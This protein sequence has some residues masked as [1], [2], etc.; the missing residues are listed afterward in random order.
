M[1]RAYLTL[2]LALIAPAIG[3]ILGL[4]LWLE[5]LAG[6]L[7]RLGGYS[8][9]AF[10]WRGRQQVFVPS[11]AQ[12]ANPNGRYDIIVIGDS[13][14]W[15][16]SADQQTRVGAFWTDFLAASTGASVGVFD[17]LALGI[18]GIFKTPAY[19]EHPPGLIILELVER[20]LQNALAAAGS[21]GGAVPEIPLATPSDPRT[22]PTQTYE[23]ARSGGSPRRGVG[24][25]VNYLRKNLPRWIAGEDL[26]P[27]VALTL[28]RSD[29]FS[30]QEPKTLLTYEDDFKKS[31]WTAADIE[32]I[33]CHLLRLQSRIESNGRTGFLFLMAP[34]KSSAYSPYLHKRPDWKE[35]LPMLIAGSALHAPRADLALRSAIADLVRDVYL[36]NDTHWGTAGSRVAAD[37]VVGYLREHYL[38]GPSRR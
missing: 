2:L 31:Q 9:N 15:R 5:P 38:R 3:V 22:H 10:G 35:T 28:D 13:F 33:R 8:E 11:L 27:V 4:A 36:P 25:A 23:R 34:D 19:V 29:L 20:S 6:D 14:S 26:T 12:A 24:E 7:T 1:Y 21:C 37:A 17:V 30:N 16:T 32:A 18:D